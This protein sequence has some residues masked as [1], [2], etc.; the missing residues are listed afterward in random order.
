MSASVRRPRQAYLSAM[1]RP[2][3]QIVW[4]KRDLRVHDHAPLGR[5]RGA[6]PGA[7]ALRARTRLLARARR[8]RPPPRVP[9]REPGR[10]SRGA[11]CPRP[12]P[13]RPRRRGRSSPG[14]PPT[15]T[16][17]R[18]AV[19]ARGDR[20]R[21]DL[22]PRPPRPRL[23][24]RA[25]HPL[26]RAAPD[27]RDPPPRASRRLGAPMGP[28][29]APAAGAGTAAADGACPASTR[30]RSRRRTRWA[31]R[32]TRAPSGSAAAAA[33]GRRPCAASSTTRGRPYRKAMSSPAAGAVHCS[34][35]SPH[36]AWGTVSIREALQAA[37]ARLAGLA[38]DERPAW[39][40]SLASF[41]GRLHWH[42]HF[43]Q[44]LESE[45][46]IECRTFHPAYEG[47]RGTDERRASPPGPRAAPAGRSST[48]ACACCAP[49]AGSTSACA[50]W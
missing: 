12:A 42:C 2:P 50:P 23:G 15:A 40:G 14:G 18:R 24:R 1:R 17:H 28:A 34:R 48:P 45:P 35:L 31:S 22:R 11:G 27:R 10:A 44:K 46:R 5:G 21:L 39:R 9:V 26:A 47:L 19:V 7:A 20:Q 13:D 37:E 25:R 41:I 36:L 30:D 43:I 4:F 6:R 38:P 49:P 33:P 29:D 16:S 3:V 8:Q 32:P